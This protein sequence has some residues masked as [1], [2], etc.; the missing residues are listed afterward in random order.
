MLLARA[1]HAKLSQLSRVVRPSTVEAGMLRRLMNTVVFISL[2]RSRRCRVS[3]LSSFGEVLEGMFKC[4]ET[5]RALLDK[6]G[7]QLQ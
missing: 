2:R 7:Y 3:V 6:T 5:I 4:P 1:A